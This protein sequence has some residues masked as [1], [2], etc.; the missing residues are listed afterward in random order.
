[1]QDD[2]T[3]AGERGYR[4]VFVENYPDLFAEV[5]SPSVQQAMF[6]T[7]GHA[8]DRILRSDDLPL[9]AKLRDT[10]ENDAAVE[11]AFLAALGRHP[12]RA[13][14]E[15]SVEFLDQR[16]DRREEAIRQFLWALFAGAE[17]R[18]NH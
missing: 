1:V 3:V 16:G 9:V 17:F 10:A 13:E 8:I 4:D 7:N 18:I 5:F 2:G 6:T 11:H 12:D 15:R 14:R